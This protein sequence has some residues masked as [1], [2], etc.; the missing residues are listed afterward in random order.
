VNCSQV[1]KLMHYLVRNHGLARGLI[2]RMKVYKLN[3]LG[4]PFELEALLAKSLL[5]ADH[6]L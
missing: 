1:A 5:I 2:Q 4:R 3:S 6:L